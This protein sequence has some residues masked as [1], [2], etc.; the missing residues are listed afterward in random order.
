MLC[1]QMMALACQMLAI[2]GAYA[3]NSSSHHQSV[4][5]QL[6]FRVLSERDVP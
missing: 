4:Q 2:Y 3:T 5:G 6:C 1:D